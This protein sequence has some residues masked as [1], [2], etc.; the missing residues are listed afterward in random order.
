M[1]QYSKFKLKKFGIIIIFGLVGF[2]L[3]N[4][5][6]STVSCQWTDDEYAKL[7]KL[8]MPKADAEKACSSIK[9]NLFYGS[10]LLFAPIAF[11]LIMYFG[12]LRK[13]EKEEDAIMKRQGNKC[14]RCSS[15]IDPMDETKDFWV[16]REQDAIFCER[17]GILLGYDKDKGEGLLPK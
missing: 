15:T 1:D 3:I 5:F 9:T 13:M 14:K 12:L 16:D 17:C 6:S 11:I 7:S 8:D 4:Y 2:A 10:F